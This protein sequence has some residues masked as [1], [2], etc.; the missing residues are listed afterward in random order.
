MNRRR[1]GAGAEEAA[2]DL[3]RRKG[4]RLL[5]RNVRFPFGELDLVCEQAGVVVFVEVKARSGT[6]HGHPFEAV[7]PRKQKQLGRLALAYL[8]RK[9]FVNRPCRFD[10]VAV[11]LDPEGRPVRVEVLQDAFRF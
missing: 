5:D 8:Q 11:H 7:T 10:V 9:G 2:A 6:A 4:Y 1:I 3:L